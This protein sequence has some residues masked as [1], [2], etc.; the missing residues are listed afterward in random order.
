LTTYKSCGA[1]AECNE[2]TNPNPN[3]TNSNPTKLTDPAVPGFRPYTNNE[4]F[5]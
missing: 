2:N 1:T 5:R 3:P 4:S